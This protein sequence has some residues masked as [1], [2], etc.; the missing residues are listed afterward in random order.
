LDPDDLRTRQELGVALGGLKQFDAAV[1]EFKQV[2]LADANNAKALHNL[3]LTLNQMGQKELA[4][5]YYRQAQA[6][7]RGEPTR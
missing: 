5:D 7:Q 4:L 6:I 1:L 2:L 3:A